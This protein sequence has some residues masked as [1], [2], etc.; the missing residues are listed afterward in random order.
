[1]AKQVFRVPHVAARVY[2]PRKADIYRR[3][4]IQTISPVALGA[5]RL[6]ELLTFTHLD[7]ES[8]LGTG[9]VEIVEVEVPNS[10]AG[11]VVNDIN[12]PGEVQVVS[13]TRTG[14]TF[15]PSSNT[16]LQDGDLLHITVIEEHRDRI[17]AMFK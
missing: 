1:M 8:V 7:T 12:V 9:E 3:L 6:A 15:L 10:Y 4:G 5:S 16:P 13:I 17:A 2:D 14:K 11:R